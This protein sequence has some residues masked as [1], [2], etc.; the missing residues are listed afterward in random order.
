MAPAALALAA[1]AAG[2][3]AAPVEAR[4]PKPSPKPPQQAVVLPRGTSIVAHARGRQIRVFPGRGAKRPKLVLRTRAAQR[5]PIVFLVKWER[6][7]WTRPRWVR[8]YLPR[9]PNGSTGWVRSSAV[10]FYRNPYRLR[11]DLRRHRLTVWKRRRVVLRST[12]AVGT[13]TTPTPAGRYF[14]R[15]LVRPSNPRGPFGP[16]VYQTSAYSPVLRRFAGGPGQIGLHGTNAPRRLGTN[17]SH[18][19]IR[20]RNRHIRRLSR[21]LPLGTP[22]RIVRGRTMAVWPSGGSVARPTRVSR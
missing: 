1:L 22:I 12:I 16:F 2:A 13:M 7:R 20:V 21:L 19:C 14:V 10:R 9:R 11:V 18:G 4:K 8:V 17:V 5:S 6:R 3:A 15:R